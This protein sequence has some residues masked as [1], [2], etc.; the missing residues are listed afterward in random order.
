MHIAMHACHLLNVAFPERQC[1]CCS[2]HVEICAHQ[3]KGLCMGD[4]VGER[5][6]STPTSMGTIHLPKWDAA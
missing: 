1:L 4:E 5:S 6:R 2:M 3:Q